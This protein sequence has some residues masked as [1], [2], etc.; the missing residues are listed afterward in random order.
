MAQKTL[1]DLSKDMA[2]IDY[3]M[4]MTRAENGHIAGRP[5]SNNGEVEYK[6]DSYFFALDSTHTVGEIARDPKVAL[7]FAGREGIV[8]QRPVFINVEG[9]AELIR[10]KGQFQAHWTTDLDRWFE[11]GID[12]PGLVMIKVHASRIHYWAGEEEGELSV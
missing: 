9:Q 8:G 5:M 3:A 4:L 7:A 12:T 6:G 11:K 1:A 2:K 10:D